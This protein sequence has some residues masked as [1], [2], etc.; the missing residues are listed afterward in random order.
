VPLQDATGTVSGHLGK[1]SYFGLV[2]LRAEDGVLLR[3]EILANPYLKL[4]KQ[5]GLE[6]AKL[7]VGR[8]IDVLLVKE[9]LE[10]KGPSYVL[11]DAGVETRITGAETLNQVLA[12]LANQ[13]P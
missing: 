1:A 6:V 3:Q 9:S 4:E 12:E 10:G 8:G 5:K 11:A 2:E 13:G 7:L